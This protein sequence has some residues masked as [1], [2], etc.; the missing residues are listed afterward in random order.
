MKTPTNVAAGFT[1]VEL[2]ITIVIATILV[3]IA[4]PSY[5][6][7]IRKSRRTEAKTAILDLAGRE[8]RLY[9]TTNTYS[10]TAADLG[11]TQF[12]QQIGG[13]YYQLTVTFPN[14]GAIGFTAT[15]TAINSQLDD[16]QCRSFSVD[17]TG[18]QKSFDANGADS[19]TVCL[20]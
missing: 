8:E 20:N 5:Q 16:T 18:Q 9:S 4:L 1:L 11:Y 10:T 17:Q 2:M 12:P 19:S 3:S 13:L 7:Q 6:Q 15:A 14:N